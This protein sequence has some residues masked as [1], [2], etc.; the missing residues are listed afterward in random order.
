[1]DENYI[2]PKL[3]K[4][5]EVM[6]SGEA[7]AKYSKQRELYIFGS[8]SSFGKVTKNVVTKSIAIYIITN[9]I[10]LKQ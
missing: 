9:K 5:C 3:L 10:I 6:Y 8:I 4:L 1:M 2:V 7:F